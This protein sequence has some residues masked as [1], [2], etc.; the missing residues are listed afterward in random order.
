M[1]KVRMGMVGGGQGAFI[2]AVHRIAAAMDGEIELVCGAFS[3][4]PQRSISSGK[5]LGV[6]V[7]RCYASYQEMFARE[8]SLAK[9]QKMDFVA[10]VTPNHLH[11]DISKMAIESGFHVL[12][13]KPATFD[14]AEAEK[15]KLLIDQHDCL[16][17]LTHAYN[18]Y[19]MIK[20]AKARIASG[21]L[22]RILKV[23]VE[24][25]QGW[26]APGLDETNKQ[27]SWRLDPTQAGVSCCVGDIGVHAANLTEYVTGR[28]IVRLYSDLN[29]IVEGR[30]LD[31]DGVVLLEF[32]N[33]AKGVLLASQICVG[34][35][36][37]L[38]LRIYG[39]KKSLEWSQLEP[40]T[41][42]LKSNNEATQML[43]SGVGQL[44]NATL[45]SMRT[46]AGHPEGYL[47]A[48]ANIYRNF[49]EL[50]RAKQAGRSQNVGLSDVP[51]IYQALRGMAFIETAVLS[52]KQKKWLSLSVSTQVEGLQNEP[53]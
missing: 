13:D 50:I 3:S 4:D 11:F 30:K 12:C 42:W 43:R 22:G 17:G 38:R 53:N 46:P 44:S 40:N 18:G 31:D 51:G 39:E 47:E 33:Q 15:L 20:E 16:Y 6:P 45:S 19:P 27:A 49:A 21:E 23:V 29:T 14:L 35:E 24:Y 32:D 48:F 37:N 26:L 34:E 2:G 8:S 41:L 10:I 52:S 7:E 9:E 25:H 36:N 1:K 28:E 5:E